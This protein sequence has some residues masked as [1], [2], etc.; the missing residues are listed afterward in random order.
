M[1]SSGWKTFWRKRINIKQALSGWRDAATSRSESAAA[2]CPAHS[3][4]CTVGL[5]HSHLDK[6]VYAQ[7]ARLDL[8]QQLTAHLHWIRLQDEAFNPNVI[9]KGNG[10][11]LNPALRGRLDTEIASLPEVPPFLCASISGNEYLYVGHTEHPRP[12]D[13]S[14]PE[15]P[16]LPVRSGVEII[17]PS[18]MRKTLERFMANALSI[19]SALH[20]AIDIPIV[21]IQS[22]PP[23]SSADHIRN[24]PG[25]FREAIQ[26]HGVAPASLRM[27]LW[28]LQSTIYRQRCEE[29]GCRYLEVPEE[30]VDSCGFLQETGAWPDSV[31]ANTWYGELV[32]RKIELAF[33]ES[34]KA[35]VTH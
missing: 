29:L 1:P 6:L 24:N 35:E 32:I 34:Q 4:G 33:R 28:L 3:L 19:M 13:F 22:P 17:A 15:R 18:L 21:F 30:A 31:H 14:L 2:K 12:F 10:M 8:G 20:D 9:S 11:V 16:D 27:K 23:I 26:E 5:G 7:Q 25:P